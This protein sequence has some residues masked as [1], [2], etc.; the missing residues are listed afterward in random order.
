MNISIGEVLKLGVTVMIVAMVSA[1]VL[2]VA[3][4]ITAPVIEK[5]QLAEIEESLFEFIP[6]ADELEIEE[7]EDREFYLA[8]KEGE[9]LGVA[10]T[11]TTSGYGGDIDMMVGVNTEGH[12]KGIDI[13]AHE[14]TP[15]L[16]DVIEKDDFREQFVSI[17][18]E[19]DVSAKVDV[20]SGSTVSVMAAI[21]GAQEGQE[22]LA[23]DYLG[24]EEPI[25][26]VPPEKVPDGTYEGEAM[27]F[28]DTVTLEVTVEGGEIVEI[29]K[30]EHSDT[31]EYWED[32]WPET[33][34]RIKEA[35]SMEVEAVSGATGSSEGIKGAVIDALH[36]EAE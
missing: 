3:D 22:I 12:I 6:E 2:T 28:N 19:T 26:D 16:G 17:D 32:A 13:L 11:V 24:F 34:E 1:G 27:G 7:V 9:M 14:E 5:Q 8:M 4:G 10:T 30:I 20:I 35:Q 31:P 23:Y 33:A 25:S 15:G 36:E 18:K 21:S 29:E